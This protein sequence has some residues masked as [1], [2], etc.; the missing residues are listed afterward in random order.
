[1]TNWGADIHNLNKPW[2]FLESLC[3]TLGRIS[4]ILTFRTLE[5]FF[6]RILGS[7][8]MQC[9]GKGLFHQSETLNYTLHIELFALVLN[10]AVNFI[11]FFGFNTATY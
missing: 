2:N 1:L 3:H 6:H 7:E 11:T 8:E 5:E 9:L 10:I 4:E